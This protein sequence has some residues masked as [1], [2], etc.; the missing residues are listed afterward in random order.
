M[1]N[2][3]L[4]FRG[5]DKLGDGAYG[6]SRGDRL[7]NGVDLACYPG[8]IINCS[9][10]GVVTKLGY[11]YGDDLSFRYVQVTTPS[12]ADMRYFYVSPSVEVGDSVE[13]GQMLGYS[14]ELGKRYEGITE[15]IHVEVKQGGEYL[16]PHD[17]I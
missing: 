10:P 6:A 3:Q 12:G 7:H 13:V 4:P 11:P 8:T 17:F 5:T 16:N 14:Q 2:A 15:H 9:R 1:I